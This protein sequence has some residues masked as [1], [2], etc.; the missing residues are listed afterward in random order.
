MWK[1]EEEK[2]RRKRKRENRP[3]SF[4]NESMTADIRSANIVEAIGFAIC[5]MKKWM[6]KEVDVLE[7]DWL[8]LTG[9]PLFLF[10]MFEQL[11][12]SLTQSSSA[13]PA[14]IVL[15]H[16]LQTDS[17]GAEEQNERAKERETI[18][19]NM[20]FFL[21]LCWSKAQN[22]QFDYLSQQQF[23][24]YYKSSKSKEMLF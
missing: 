10:V 16:L 9:S 7:G 11:S 2:P 18:Q 19:S 8:L 1:C 5:T 4:A 22:L 3:H 24:L 20:T 17:R 21:Q 14:L 15:L 13:I 23:S 6:R 12:F